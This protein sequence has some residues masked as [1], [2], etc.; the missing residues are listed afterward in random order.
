MKR[1][2]F[3]HFIASFIVLLTLTQ[4]EALQNVWVASAGAKL[5]TDKSASSRTLAELP[6]GMKLTV[7]ALEN[8]WY[9]V[10]TSSGKKGWIYRGRTS[11]K[12]PATSGEP[13]KKDVLGGLLAGATRGS[14][15]ADEADTD[16]SIRGLS[17]EARKYA[18]QTGKS[19]RYQKAVDQVLS[20]QIKDAEIERFLQKGNIGEYAQ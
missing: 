9:F 5:K 3:R 16:R 19:K 20:M 2:I 8:R 4:A 15:R 1:I 13:G 18:R 11:S 6:V 10:K 7:L 14:I 17:P 12:P